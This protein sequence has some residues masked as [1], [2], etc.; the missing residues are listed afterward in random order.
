MVK[1]SR[2]NLKDFRVLLPSLTRY[3]PAL[4]YAAF[5]AI[6]FALVLA[7]TSA[8]GAGVST[9]SVNYLSAA[10]HWSRGLGIMDY[11]GQPMFLWPPLYPAILGTLNFFTRLPLELVGRYLNA[12]VFAAIILISAYLM[13]QALPQQAAWRLWANLALVLSPS[14]LALCSNIGSDG[15]FI[16]LILLFIAAAQAWLRTDSPRWLALMTG[17]AAAATLVRWTGAVLLLA[18]SLWLLYVLRCNPR[19]ALLRVLSFGVLASLP[20]AG[21]VFGRNY[22][23]YGSLVG[24]RDLSQINII[25]NLRYTLARAAVWFMPNMVIDRFWPL[26][27][28]FLLLA[29]L[30]V[31]I[32]R[33]GRSR[34]VA[35]LRSPSL[36]L[37]WI[38]LLAYLGFILVTTFTGDHIDTYDDR[39]QAP[40]FVPL[41][42]VFLACLRELLEAG[43]VRLRRWLYL[44]VTV[45]MVAW[46]IYPAFKVYKFVKMSRDQGVVYYNMFNTRVLRESEFVERLQKFPYKPDTRLYSN[47]PSAVYYFT[48]RITRQSLLDPQNYNASTQWLLDNVKAWPQEER[49][50]FIWMFRNDRRRYFGPNQ[51]KKVAHLVLRYADTVGEIYEIS[52]KER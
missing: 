5:G 39:Y 29:G 7:A 15:V 51:I 8:Y 23:R 26:L 40:I 22:L 35:C 38:F 37:Y 6:G 31:L 32:C 47:L 19:Q 16:L 25:G 50:Y 17:L 48:G 2:L 46:L 13:E 33:E 4:L 28:V 18:G 42:L 45:G 10:D 9:D 43:S 11:R 27:A 52:P 3:R 34:L 12:L 21:W 1:L 44:V 36:A 30:G 41:L 49:A 20:L 14:I 24:T